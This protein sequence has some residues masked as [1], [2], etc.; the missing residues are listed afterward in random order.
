MSAQSVESV[1]SK[2]MS[3]TAFARYRDLIAGMGYDA[4]QF[5]RQPQRWPEAEPRPP[6]TP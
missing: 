2:A 3:D 1:L 4:T 5:V 6:L